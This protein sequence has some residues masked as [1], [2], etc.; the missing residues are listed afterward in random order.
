MKYLFIIDDG[1]GWL[2]V[3]MSKLINRKTGEQYTE[4]SY[5]D[6]Q[7]AYL[8]EDCDASMFVRMHT[9]SEG[10]I[11]YIIHDG[12]SWIRNLPALKS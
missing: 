5:T 7:Y 9:I 12:R 6:G 8:E 2:R 1:H 10:D 4:Y 3:P 11:E